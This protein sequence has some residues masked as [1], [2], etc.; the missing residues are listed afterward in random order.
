APPSFEEVTT[1]RT[2]PDSVEVNTLI[3]SGIIAPANVPQ[4]MMVDSCHQIL[5]SPRSRMRPY[6]TAYVVTTDTIEVNHTS[7]VSGCSKF[8]LSTVLYFAFAAISLIK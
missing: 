5:P 3:T 8:I 1:S 2:C 7:T 6:E 4:L